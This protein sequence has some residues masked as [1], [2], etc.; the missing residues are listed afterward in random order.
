MIDYRGY[1]RSNG[2]PTERGLYADAAAAY[3]WARQQG[4]AP[5]R[6]VVHGESLGSAVAI[7][8]ASQRPCAAVVL[9]APFPS[10][11]QVA[12]TVLPILGPLLIWGYDSRSKIPKVNVPVLIIQGDRD[13]VIALRLGQ[14]LFAA[15]HEPKSFWIVPGA[16]HNDL[17]ETAG[18]EY[19][20]RLASF[21]AS[22]GN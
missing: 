17:V 11:K 14:A 15:A 10:A 4:Y 13:E 1:G 7:D 8:L 18:P 6:I 5:D 2:R 16:G 20:R 21:Y 12:S 3:D 22:V 19:R 9:E